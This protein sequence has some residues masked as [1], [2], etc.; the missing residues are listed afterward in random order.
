MLTL[1]KVSRHFGGLMAVSEVDMQ[2]EKGQIVGLIGPNGAGKTTLINCISGLDHPSGGVIRLQGADIQ[3]QPPHRI[4]MRGLSRTYQ[5]IRLFAEMS[6]QENVIVAQHRQ[7]SA[8][9][10]HSLLQLP[11]HRR[12]IQMQQDRAGELLK[13]FKLYDVRDAPAASLPYGD[14]RRLEMARALATAPDIILLD[15]PTAG[16]NA[17]ETR[18]SGDQLLKLRDE[19]MTLLVIEH[20]MSLISQVCDRVYVLNFGKMIA[21]GT[22]D[23]IKHNPDVIKAYLG[24]EENAN[25][26]EVENI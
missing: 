13:R 16:M 14:Q 3:D 26:A 21:Q 5:N 11:T 7:G 10:L 18:E 20:D 12:E 6:V 15:E 1:E 23:E 22:P 17:I 9:L 19:G 25:E 2:I 24:E 4:T 8:T